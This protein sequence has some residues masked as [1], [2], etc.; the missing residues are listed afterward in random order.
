M[1]S[2][3]GVV[4]SGTE[5]DGVLPQVLDQV[6]ALAH[7]EQLLDDHPGISLPEVNLNELLWVNRTI[8]VNPNRHCFKTITKLTASG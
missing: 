1:N 4:V 3:H 7:V 6:P 2:L 8:K 5:P